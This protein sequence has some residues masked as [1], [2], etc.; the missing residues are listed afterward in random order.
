M[1]QPAFSLPRIR[2]CAR[3]IA[4]LGVV[5]IGG[6]TLLWARTGPMPAGVNVWSG[7]YRES[8]AKRGEAFYVRHCIN[9]HAADLSGASSYDPS[10]PLVGRP[11]QLTWKG[12]S[13]QDLFALIS[14]TMP[15]DMPGALTPSEYADILAYIFREN[16]FPAGATDLPT[17]AESLRQ[18]EFT[19][20]E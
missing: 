9:C 7:V 8:Q 13:V 11:F 20:R 4:C 12:K 19:L 5:M 17:D 6:A 10:P 2:R 16:Q 14:V 15:K 1:D 3:I 18:I